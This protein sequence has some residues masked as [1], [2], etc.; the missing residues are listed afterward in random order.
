MQTANHDFTQPLLIREKAGMMWFRTKRCKGM[1]PQHRKLHWYIFRK[2]RNLLPSR[3]LD[4]E[5]LQAAMRR[6]G[7]I[8]IQGL[9]CINSITVRYI[10]HCLEHS[11]K[12]IALRLFS[13]WVTSICFMRRCL[14]KSTRTIRKL[15]N[16]WIRSERGPVFRGMQNFRNR[17]RKLALSEI[18]K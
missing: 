3:Y 8:P 16:I 14:T 5:A 15:L 13:D 1:M 6:P 18:R 12:Y 2:I 17:E 7:T 10:L 11:V 4:T 9:W